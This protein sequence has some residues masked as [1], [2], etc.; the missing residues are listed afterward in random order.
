MASIKDFY[1]DIKS[2]KASVKNNELSKLYQRP[3]KETGKN[4][5]EFHILEPNYL[6]NCDTLYMPEDTY[7]GK[8]YKYLLV[9]TDVYSK[10]MDAEPYTNLKQDSHEV[11]DALK[12]IYKRGIVK[13]PKI[14]VFDNGNENGD[15]YLKKYLYEHKINMRFM[16]PGRYRQISSVKASKRKLASILFRFMA[17]EELLTGEVSRNWVPEVPDLVEAIN[18]NLPPPNNDIPE[19]LLSTKFSGKMLPIGARVR[20][21]LDRP[22]DTVKG[23]LM[24]G[25][26]RSTDIR[27]DP[28][29]RRI[30]N[31]LLKP[32]CVPLY[33]VSDDGD[34][35]VARTKNQLQLVKRNERAPDIKYLRGDP[36]YAIIN[37]IKDYRKHERK[38]EYLVGFKG[39]DHTHDRWVGVKELN[40]TA[41]LRAMKDEFNEHRLQGQAPPPPVVHQQPVPPPPPPP[42]PVAQAPP[43]VH[44]YPLRSRQNN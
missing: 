34:K 9:V 19:K 10:K 31:I 41:D 43:P 30:E 22:R 5:P 4:M 3:I 37:N 7:K 1:N 16:L 35:L 15:T 18:E 11:L 6:Q 17:N 24:S 8:K 44:R 29:V 12:K 23:N 36:E 38:D 20:V 42:P 14:L 40:R 2:K 39:Y 26:F 27:W 21:L 13:Y 32:G 25:T 33:I 28:N